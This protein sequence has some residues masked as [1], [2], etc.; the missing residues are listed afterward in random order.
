LKPRV[1]EGA[2]VSWVNSRS[3]GNCKTYTGEV[4]NYLP[5]YSYVPVTKI[6]EGD[7]KRFQS[8]CTGHAR[9]LVKCQEE[10]G[11]AKRLVNVWHCPFAGDIES[12][13]QDL[14]EEQKQ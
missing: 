6:K 3:G 10:F 2:I 13:N 14:L 8:I 7:V 9:Y 11:K 4:V 12:Q 1:P 5:P